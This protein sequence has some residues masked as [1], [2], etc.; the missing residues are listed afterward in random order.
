MKD[1]FKNRF[2]RIII[3]LEL[4]V[5]LYFVADCF[6]RL[7]SYNIPWKEM[8]TVNGI[9]SE[10]GIYTDG[11][12]GVK[13]YFVYGPSFD[14]DRGIYDITVHYT[15]DGDTNYVLLSA[16]NEGAFGILKDDLKLSSE[17]SEQKFTAWVQKDVT[18]FAVSVIYDGVGRLTVTDIVIEETRA[19]KLHSLILALFW[20]TLLNLVCRLIDMVK[21]G[22]VC[23]EKLPYV[24][25]MAGIVIFASY[26]LFTRFLT[27]GHDLV[28]HLLRIEGI[29]QGLLAGQFP[30]RIQP[31]QYRGYGYACSVFYGELLLYIPALLRLCGFTIQ[32][33]YKIFV[34]LVNLATAL[35][36]YRSMKI[37]VKEQK[38]AMLCCMVYVLSP[39]RLANIYV[40]SAVGEYCAMMF[41]PLIAA[42][43]Y[44]L[45]TIEDRDSRE[46]KRIW[47]W[48][49]IGYSGLIQTHLLSCEL[50]AAAS[51]VV[52]LIMW[53]KTFTGK[54]FTELLK[55]FCMTV[56]LN[57]FYLIPFF[58]YLIRGGVYITEYGAGHAGTMQGNGIYPAHLFQLFV[59]GSGMAY[60]HTLDAYRILGMSGEMGITVG[61]ALILGG[62]VFLYLWISRYHQIKQQKLF[63]LTAGMT[64]SGFLMLYM[65]T[66]YFPWDFLAKY[67]GSL[68]DNLQFPWRML[69]LGTV[70]FTVALG[71]TLILCRD[72][73]KK[74][75]CCLITGIICLTAVI[76]ASY[77]FYNRLETGEVYYV[78]DGTSLADR[79]TGSLDEYLLA[80]TTPKQLHVY[81][82]LV[83]ENIRL[84]EYEKQYTNIIMTVKEC[85]N[86]DGQIHVPLLGYP[87]YRAVDE[88]GN[89]FSL[90]KAENG[91]LSVM[92]PAGYEG[93][94][95]IYFAGFW[96]WRAAE[97][98]SLISCCIFLGFA[99]KFYSRRAD[100]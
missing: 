36:V 27:E 63:W 21:K 34:V 62:L 13:G 84:M 46:F 45:Y 52:C 88:D 61:I 65:A 8:E 16:Q 85:E 77:M 71:G 12:V 97:I 10:E 35:I 30:V 57:A 83:S 37:I 38:I 73:W 75:I 23:R 90:T 95:K 2:Y 24:T 92:I 18:D 72:V 22:T 51:V 3:I 66:M 74:E 54:I 55:F 15:C 6:T 47:I 89:K 56:L 28:F 49:V 9:E 5:I 87:G 94:I 99:V 64:V 31:V 78:Y 60:G 69:S 59:S 43:L 50:A 32:N 14:L 19:G 44:R 39:Y 7:S 67:L 17:L 100:I 58:S 48:L 86:L 76:T 42:A 53:R 26:P 11:S 68:V 93:N 40:R 96:F 25:A 20:I 98:I 70:F 29:A 1:F 82:P 91:M 79:G 4:I 81:E 41:W 80:E 33:A